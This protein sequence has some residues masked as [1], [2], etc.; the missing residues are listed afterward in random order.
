MGRLFLYS[1]KRIV[2]DNDKYLTYLICYIH[3]NPIHHRFT[4]S[5]AAWK[6][7][8]Y[9]AILSDIPSIIS[10][11]LVLSFFGSLDEFLSFHE[12]SKELYDRS[13]YLLE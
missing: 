9:N 2:V 4:E 7:S 10:K 12:D 1:F 3:R 11:D 5:Y 8:S 6:Y 13:K